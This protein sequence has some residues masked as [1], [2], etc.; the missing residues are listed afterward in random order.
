MAFL[1]TPVK[2]I[3]CRY[4][5]ALQDRL[6]RIVRDKNMERLQNFGIELEQARNHLTECPHG[7]SVF[8]RTL[9]TLCVLVAEN[10]GVNP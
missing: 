9:A 8:F 5:S 3:P 7:A 6:M 4:C 10:S 1:S 2:A